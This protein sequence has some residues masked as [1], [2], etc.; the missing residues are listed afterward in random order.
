MKPYFADTFYFLARFNPRDEHH[1]RVLAWSR[2]HTEPLMTTE[3]VL[4]ELANSVARSRYRAV[5]RDFYSLLR[6]HGFVT[7]LDD[8][9]LAAAWSLYHQH[10]DKAWSLT[11]CYSFVV[12][13]ENGWRAALTNDHHFRQAGFMAV[14]E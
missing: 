12:M 1:E 8:R 9:R 11:D 7:P 13:R 2:E 5:V 10:D 3:L 14:F 4:I 6:R